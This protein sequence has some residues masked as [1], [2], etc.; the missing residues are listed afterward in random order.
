MAVFCAMALSGCYEGQRGLAVLMV[1]P[2]GFRGPFTIVENPGGS[3][4]S[5]DGSRYVHR[6]PTNGVLR[7]RARRGF[8]EW[9]LTSP[10]FASGQ[11][12][13]VRITTDPP[14]SA[15]EVVLYEIDSSATATYFFVGT[16]SEMQHFLEN[17]PPETEAA[18]FWAG[19]ALTNKDT[20]A[21][22]RFVEPSAKQ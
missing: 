22:R 14:V 17:R 11:S 10:Q 21:W 2:D 13:P 5:L 20:N 4:I 7:V 16:M 12:L 18:A 19:G 15:G 6:L 8:E 1:V 3:A 9:H